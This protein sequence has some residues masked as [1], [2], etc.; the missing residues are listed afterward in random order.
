MVGPSSNQMHR[1]KEITSTSKRK[2][3]M[4]SSEY[5]LFRQLDDLVARDRDHDTEPD[6]REKSSLYQP[7]R[8]PVSN[9][10]IYIQRWRACDG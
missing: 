2:H 10:G 1:D 6:Q 4:F 7:I 5:V 3:D 9:L 8:I